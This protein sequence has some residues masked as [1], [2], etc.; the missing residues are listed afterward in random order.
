MLAELD[1]AQT[2][3][4][5]DSLILAAKHPGPRADDLAGRGFGG[6]ESRCETICSVLL[7]CPPSRRSPR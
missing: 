3:E 1:H 6:A 7:I 4:P 5:D 2:H